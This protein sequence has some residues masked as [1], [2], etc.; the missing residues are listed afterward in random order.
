[1]SAVAQVIAR[2][3]GPVLLRLKGENHR[4]QVGSKIPRVYTR[5]DCGCAYLATGDIACGDYVFCQR[6]NWR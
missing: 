6:H 1:M 5:L 3:D 2:Q 4:Q